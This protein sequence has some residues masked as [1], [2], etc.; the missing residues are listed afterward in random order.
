[1]R[2]TFSAASSSVETKCDAMDGKKSGVDQEACR[3]RDW[4]VSRRSWIRVSLWIAVSVVTLGF[5]SISIFFIVFCSILLFSSE[6]KGPCMV[7]IYRLGYYRKATMSRCVPT[8]SRLTRDI[9]KASISKNVDELEPMNIASLSLLALE[10]A[11]G[12]VYGIICCARKACADSRR[13]RRGEAN[14]PHD[15]RDFFEMQLR[16]I[17]LSSFCFHFR[18]SH[19]SWMVNF[20]FFQSGSAWW[21]LYRRRRCWCCCLISDYSLS[22]N[23]LLFHLSAMTSS[24]LISLRR[25][26]FN[27]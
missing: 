19:F 8:D 7:L 6:S 20:Y 10:V 4:C 22:V 12:L 13:Q 16:W 23:L 11:V 14:D 18:W 17:S 2:P 21:R 25:I 3:R 1:M 24:F 5:I 26:N 27:N 15:P 9:V